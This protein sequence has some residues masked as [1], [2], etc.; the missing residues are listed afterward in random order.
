MILVESVT[1][2]LVTIE[3]EFRIHSAV[4]KFRVIYLGIAMLFNCTLK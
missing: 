4:V 2:S 1:F 3:S